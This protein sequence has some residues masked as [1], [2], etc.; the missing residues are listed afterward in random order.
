MFL[1][2]HCAGCV[3][4]N[5]SLSTSLGENSQILNNFEALS[6]N[7]SSQTF[8]RIYDPE[9]NRSLTSQDDTGAFDAED[10]VTLSLV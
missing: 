8:D 10:G 2:I 1:S 5:A 4:L 7:N 9:K 3:F 6:R